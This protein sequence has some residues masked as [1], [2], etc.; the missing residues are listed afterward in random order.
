MTERKQRP[1]SPYELG[2]AVSY[3]A[4]FLLSCNFTRI[5]VL[6][7]DILARRPRID[8]RRRLFIIH[9]CRLLLVDLVFVSQLHLNTFLQPAT[10]HTT[11]GFSW[12]CRSFTLCAFKNWSPSFFVKYLWHTNQSCVSLPWPRPACLLVK[13]QMLLLQPIYRV[14]RE[15]KRQRRLWRRI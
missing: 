3:A 4:V 8:S 7:F 13:V 10:F 15:L 5:V 2:C 1:S 6:L 14:Q 9:L 12:P 11:F